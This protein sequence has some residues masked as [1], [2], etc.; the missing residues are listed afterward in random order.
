MKKTLLLMIMALVCFGTIG[1]QDEA[2][3]PQVN[4][5]LMVYKTW[6][7]VFDGQPDAVVTNHFYAQE[8]PF[9]VYIGSDSE[10]VSR[11][12]DDEAAIVAQGDTVWFISARW[13]NDHFSGECRKMSDW[14][15]LFFSAKVA[16]VQWGTYSLMSGVFGGLVDWDVKPDLYLLDFATHKVEKV[17]HKVLSRLLSDYPDLQRRYESMKD[18]KKSHVIENYL[19]EY[20]DRLNDDPNVPYLF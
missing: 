3:W 17:D 5:T 10:R 8:M 7:A 6:E 14:V 13:L 12:L 15:P 4:D 20:V 19:M 1:A 2:E 16:F 11:L 9:E 18:Y